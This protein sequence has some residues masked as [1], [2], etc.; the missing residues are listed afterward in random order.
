[1][2]SPSESQRIRDHRKAA[3]RTSHR[4]GGFLAGKRRRLIDEEIEYP[5]LRNPKHQTL[6]PYLFVSS[7]EPSSSSNPPA[8]L[9]P[10]STAA[11]PQ[12][13][14]DEEMPEMTRHR[15]SSDSPLHLTVESSPPP[16]TTVDSH[17]PPVATDKAPSSSHNTSPVDDSYDSDGPIPT[18]AGEDVLEVPL[19]PFADR[20]AAHMTLV[21]E[22]DQA[23]PTFRRSSIKPHNPI[24]ISAQAVK[25]YKHISKREFI[26]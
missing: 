23:D 26:T 3:H 15:V 14:P 20:A 1:M 13:V 18:A 10:A 21:A 16:R 4:C 11:N 5:D 2:S 7:T 12:I 25:R 22:R 8:P 9:R 24:Y 19:V 6:R 17:S